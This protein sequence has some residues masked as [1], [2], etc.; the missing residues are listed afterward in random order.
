[1]KQQGQLLYRDLNN[2]VKGEAPYDKAKADQAIAGLLDTSSRIAAA[3]PES[4]KGK[5]SPDTR[6]SAS[7][8]VWNNRA[9][10]EADI[11][12][13]I[14]ALKDNRAKVGTLEGLKVAYPV[15]SGT[16]NTCHDEFRVRRN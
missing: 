16:C 7:P 14:Q 1:M 2:M 8:K 13:L 9:E 15:I 5:M 11:A 10:F 6:F 12:N 4:S 3:F